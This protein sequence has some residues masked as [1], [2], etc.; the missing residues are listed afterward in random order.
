LTIYRYALERRP[1]LASVGGAIATGAI[2]GFLTPPAQAVVDAVPSGRPEHVSITA[3][4]VPKGVLL[5]SEDFGLVGVYDVD[6]LLDPQFTRLLDNFAASPGAFTAVRFFGALNSGERENTLPTGNG[7]VWRRREETPDFS[8][9]LD[10][11]DALVS[12]GLAPFL[13]LSFFPMAVSPSPVVPPQDFVVWTELVQAF[14]N[15]A[16]VRFGPEEVLRWRFEVWNE[17]NFQPFWAGNFKQY[18]DLYRATNEAVRRSGYRVRLGGPTVVYTPDSDGAELIERFLRFLADEPAVQCNFVSYHRKGAWLL[19]QDAPWLGGLQDAAEQIAQAVLRLV[20]ERAHGLELINNEGDM[21]VGFTKPFEP[22]MTEQFPAWLAASLIVHEALSV[23]YAAQGMRF[24]AASDDANQHLVQAPF[25]GRRS[26]MT[27]ASNR[28]DDLLKLP[29]YAFYELLRLLGSRHAT[30]VAAPA[31]ALFPAN[32]LLHLATVDDKYFGV[33]LVSYPD[34][35]ASGDAGGRRWVVDYTLED[36]PW[37]RIN[38]V[39]FSI[40]HDHTNPLDEARGAGSA[41]MLESPEAIGRVRAAQ[42]LGVI[43]SIKSG[44]SVSKGVFRDSIG[45]AP[46]ATALLWITPFSLDRP[47]APTLLAVELSYGNVVLRWTPTREPSFYGYE[48]FRT[49]PDGQP[50][51]CLSP[52]P[53]RSALWVDTAPPTGTHVYGVR[54]VTA[55]GISS[56]IVLASPIQI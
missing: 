28:P 26:V 51:L 14:L 49:G 45:L 9:T 6:W 7:G 52:R 8:I 27:R 43:S 18:M 38:A 15:A 36:I 16:V 21:K 10:A 50:G 56:A 44:L 20:P 46:F 40:N 4:G 29:V 13:T 48:I 2:S 37:L 53:L 25:D 1:L 39:W 24:L 32:D 3:S 47:K 31:S 35:R 12:R 30:T 17:P 11:L 23:K 33:L 55:S 41:L 42:E 19:D 5:P 54:T 22:R 34:R